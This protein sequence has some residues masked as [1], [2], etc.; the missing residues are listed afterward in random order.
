MKEE[1]N[2]G[3]IFIDL[4]AVIWMEYRGETANPQPRLGGFQLAGHWEVPGRIVRIP[5]TPLRPQAFLP[6]PIVFTCLGPCCQLRL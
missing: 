2:Y 6:L 4:M 3:K 5:M 1:K